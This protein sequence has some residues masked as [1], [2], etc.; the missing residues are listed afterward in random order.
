MDIQFR[1][2]ICLLAILTFFLWSLTMPSYPQTPLNRIRQV[3][4]RASYDHGDVHAILDEAY[5]AHIGLVDGDRPVVIP[6]FFARDGSS[7]LLHG[8]RKARLF[9]RLAEGVPV[10]VSI[11]LVDALVLARSAF[12]HS[13][14]YRSVVFHSRAE[15]L[16]GDER[17]RAM[18]LLVER[19]VP[20]RA[21]EVRPVNT[22][23]SKA[24]MMLK[25]P[26]DNVVAKCRSGPPVDDEEDY[27]LE[28]WAGLVPIERRFGAPQADERMIRGMTPPVVE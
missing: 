9:R 13:V 12:S 15:V 4:K 27:V 3:P 28:V 18:D 16:E 11:A 22:Q 26:L 8:S 2:I 23:E 24:T 10:S 7:I 20:G 1:P 17:L 19:M 21:A 14:N 25:V 6:L 5:V